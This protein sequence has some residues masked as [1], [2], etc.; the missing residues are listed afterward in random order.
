[1]KG[2]YSICNFLEEKAALLP[3]F[4]PLYQGRVQRKWCFISFTAD[5]INKMYKK[6]QVPLENC[7][8]I[9]QKL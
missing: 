7:Q 2:H 8:P 1:M 3:E 4:R 5:G 6:K 9:S